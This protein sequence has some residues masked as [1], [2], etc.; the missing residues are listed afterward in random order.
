MKIILD[1]REP[2]LYDEIMTI[3]S[4]DENIYDNITLEKQVL[5]LGDIVL[6]TDENIHLCI[7]ERKSLQDL[8]A[9]VKDGR[10]EEQSYRLLHTHEY[11][12]HNIFYLIEGVMTTLK[13]SKEK[14]LVYSIM[15]SLQLFKGMSVLRSSSQN[16]T[17]KMLISMANKIKKELKKGNTL[18]FSNIPKNCLEETT[19]NENKYCNVVKKVKKENITS[20]NIGEIMLCQIPGI[21][22]VTAI[23]IMN[24][25]HSISKLIEE[26]KQNPDCLKTCMLENGG[27][28]RK[29]NKKSIENIK[30]YL[31]YTS[32]EIEFFNGI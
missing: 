32:A 8:L 15:T 31:L 2:K 30:K 21:S 23:A 28:S 27:K 11:H 18:C 19:E 14:E 29:I 24:K 20:E 1:I 13:T 25:F 9:S 10:Y 17:A 5:P 22:S 7:I 4:S 16:E 12:R 26:L 3:L 6:V